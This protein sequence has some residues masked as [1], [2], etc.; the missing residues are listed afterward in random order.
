MCALALA[1]SGISV[2][3][4]HWD[5][6]APGGVEL[7]SGHS[8]QI[9]EQDSPG[10]FQR[11]PAVEIHETISLWGTGEPV[12]LNAMFNPWGTGVALER[13]LLDKSLRDLAYAAGVSIAADTKVTHGERSDE[14]WRLLLRCGE[15]ES[16]LLN[17]RFMVIATGRVAGSLVE[18][19]PA[20]EPPHIALMMPLSAQDGSDQGHALYIE[21]ADNGWWYALPAIGGGYF[22]GFCTRRDE[23]K[24]R[25][26]SLREFFIQEL[27]RTHLLGPLLGPL[28]PNA[29]DNSRITGRIAGTSSFVGA[30]GDGWI[31]IGDAAYAPDPLSGIGVEGAIESA[32][33]GASALLEVMKGGSASTKFAEYE[34]K[35]REVADRHRRTAAYHYGCL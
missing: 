28:L 16:S 21:S 13:S 33:L 17:S 26:G 22:T 20:P 6:Y 12:T 19:P 34:D 2:T 30:A 10:L 29:T 24:K 1:R 18:R 9:L 5:G 15:T 11:L 25:Q 32:R 7:V 8:R 23:V 31:A 27:R 4:V 3:L 14:G 35:I